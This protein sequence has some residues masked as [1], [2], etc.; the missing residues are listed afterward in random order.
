[1]TTVHI[2]V[3]G[4]PP[5]PNNGARQRHWHAIAEET[6][7]WRGEAA[8]AAKAALPEGWQPLDRCRVYVVFVLGDRRDR[9]PDNLIASTKVLTDGLVDGGVMVGDSIGVIGFPSYGHRYERGVQATEYT[10]ESLESDQLAA[11]L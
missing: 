1:M 5:N 6:R 4:R 10:I 8:K 3:P 7:H 2:T 9:D 11:D